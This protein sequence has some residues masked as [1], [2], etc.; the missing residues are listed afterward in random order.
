MGTIS[1][2]NELRLMLLRHWSL[3]ESINHSNYIIAQLSLN[4]QEGKERYNELLAKLGIPLHEASQK[5]T[6][7]QPDI[8]RDLKRKV[9]DK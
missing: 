9:M 1:I 4:K 6:F 2:E 7:M 3:K 5:Y 8:R